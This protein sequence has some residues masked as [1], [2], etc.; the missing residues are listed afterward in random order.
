MQE[1][2]RG[3]IDTLRKSDVKFFIHAFQSKIFNEVLEEYDGS[4]DVEIPLANFDLNVKDETGKLVL[5]K[6]KKYEVKPEDFII[7]P[8]PE[9]IGETVYRKGFVEAEDFKIEF[10]KKTANVEFSLP[11]GSYA[12]VF[13]ESLF[14]PAKQKVF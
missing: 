10:K 8:F 7:R 12:T 2:P 13:I 6:L 14:G 9:C 4:K 1:H 11:K 5:K 3:F